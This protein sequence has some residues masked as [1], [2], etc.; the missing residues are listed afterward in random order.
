MAAAH[1]HGAPPLAADGLPVAPGP[2]APSP[3]RR[4]GRDVGLAAVARRA[5]VAGGRLARRTFVTLTRPLPSHIAEHREPAR[6]AL[7]FAG[8]IIVALTSQLPQQAQPRGSVAFVLGGLATAFGLASLWPRLHGLLNRYDGLLALAL[9][10]ALVAVTGGSASIYRPLLVLLL[11]YSALFCD[12]ARL[13]GTGVL[14]GGAVLAPLAFAGV[15]ASLVTVL[16]VEGPVWAVLAGVVH[17]LV[18]RTR[19]TARTDGLTGLSNHVTFQ[20][21]LHAEHERMRRYGSHYSVLLVDLDHFKRINDAHGHPV[22]DEVLR[23]VARLLGERARVTDTVARYGGEEFAMLLP[24]T[25]RT[26]ATAFANRLAAAVRE[27]ALP[28]AATVSI[29]VASS[30]DGLVDSAEALLAAAD[31]ALYEAKRAGRDRVAVTLPATSAFSFLTDVGSP[32]AT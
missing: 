1:R 15:D 22:G 29:G 32:A 6:T 4:G 8:I 10:A 13:V 20:T 14:I 16:L 24:E 7:V 18:Q 9:I 23:A 19:A 17:T 30:S 21:V 27:A 31:Q 12:T 25:P 11:L 2:D 5:C 3:T 28:V 26:P